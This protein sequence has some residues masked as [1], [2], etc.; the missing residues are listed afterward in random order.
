MNDMHGGVLLTKPIWDR[1]SRRVQG[2]LNR[3]S[4][5]GDYYRN[6]YRK[7]EALESDTRIQDY[8]Q[9]D[10][11]LPDGTTVIFAGD[12]GDVA[13]SV[14]EYR[15][16]G[17]KPSS[18]V[19]EVTTSGMGSGSHLAIKPKSSNVVDVVCHD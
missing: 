4:V 12:T 14:K 3:L 1:L 7:A 15:R 5:D 8:D 9:G 19:V 6:R 16:I 18:K 13:V 10:Y 17:V 2:E 11:G